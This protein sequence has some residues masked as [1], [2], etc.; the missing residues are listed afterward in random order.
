MTTQISMELDETLIHTMS[1]SDHG[2]YSSIT[3]GKKRCDFEGEVSLR[4]PEAPELLRICRDLSDEVIII[5][6]GTAN[7]AQS[8]ND[9]FNLGFKK[10]DLFAREYFLFGQKNLSPKGVLIDNQES[11]EKALEQE[12][13]TLGISAER[14]LKILE[15]S[16]LDFKDCKI[17]LWD[18]S[19][20]YQSCCRYRSGRYVD[21]VRI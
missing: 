1:V 4:R 2:K 15:F 9:S 3:K 5:A 21:E 20:A 13:E 19:I 12:L 7:Y 16:A 17:F 14:H 8:F 10:N 11:T 18:W 6:V